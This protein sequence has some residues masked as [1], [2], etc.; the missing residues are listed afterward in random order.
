MANKKEDT[1]MKAEKKTG[2]PE[3]FI[4][5]PAALGGIIL[6]IILFF[7]I[8]AKD[9]LEHIGTVVWGLVVLGVFALFFA[10]KAQKK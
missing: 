8:F 7:L 6:V 9:M 3:P 1:Q 2:S 4:A 5:I 10:Y